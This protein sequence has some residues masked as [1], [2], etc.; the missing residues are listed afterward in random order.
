MKTF[1]I[2]LLLFSFSAFSQV[3]KIGYLFDSQKAQWHKNQVLVVRDGII[4]ELNP[5]KIGKS[6]EV[7]DLSGKWV[8]PGLIDSHTHLFLNDETF[9]RD[10]S[11]GLKQWI[12]KSKEDKLALAR[13]RARQMREVGFVLA[14]DLGNQGE[15]QRQELEKISDVYIVSSGPGYAPLL[16]QLP[17]NSSKELAVEYKQITKGLI[18]HSY[19]LVKVYADEEP[20]HNFA[21]LGDL[22]SFTQ[23][24]HQQKKLV[25]VHAILKE[26]IELALASGADTLE[27]GSDITHDQLQ[28]MSKIS[29]IF[30]PTNSQALFLHP[31][32]RTYFQQDSAKDFT[33]N[34][35]NINRAHQ[36]GIP[37]AFGADHYFDFP[38]EH[39]GRNLLEILLSFKKCGLSNNEILQ[40]I[41]FNSA[42]TQNLYPVGVLT[43]GHL[44]DFN[45]YQFSPALDLNHLYKVQ[46]LFRQGKEIKLKDF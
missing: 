29:M 44:A 31:Q 24:A 14:R 32:R 34:C 39:F 33:R 13:K 43:P 17:E 36:L 6:L 27:H 40:T 30:V 25:A 2:I 11:R 45:V 5:S 1:I 15:V 9:S 7:I 8:L 38:G 20:N 10:F 46:R 3:F 41:T 22:K 42:H 35:T 16:G 37:I 19:P 28:H 21:K 12:N 18:D 4:T 26:G 23:K